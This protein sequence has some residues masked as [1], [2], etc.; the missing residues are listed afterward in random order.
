MLFEAARDERVQRKIKARQSDWLCFV[1]P[2]FCWNDWWRVDRRLAARSYNA[3][4]MR[5]PGTVYVAWYKLSKFYFRKSSIKSWVCLDTCVGEGM[6]VT[7]F[8]SVRHNRITRSQV[9]GCPISTPSFAL[10][11]G[12]TKGR[13]G[14]WSPDSQFFSFSRLILEQACPS[15]V[16]G[17]QY[18]ENYI[19]FFR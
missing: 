18:L 9:V 6:S 13:R 3:G 16:C 19:D 17:L 15:L 2:V 1:A 12:V 4:R 7:V 8:A 10:N 11:F 14:M 5:R